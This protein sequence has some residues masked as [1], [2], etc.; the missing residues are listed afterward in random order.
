VRKTR[1]DFGIPINFGKMGIYSRSQIEGHN[2]AIGC[3]RYSMVDGPTAPDGI[4]VYI[5]PDVLW[6]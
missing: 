3:I 4:N 2:C 1:V 6:E 5:K